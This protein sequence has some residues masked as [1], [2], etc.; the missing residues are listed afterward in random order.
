MGRAPMA[1]GVRLWHAAFAYGTGV[2]A[3]ST[4]RSHKADPM[5]ARPIV[6]LNTSD[7]ASS[8]ER[9]ADCHS[10]LGFMFALENFIFH[11]R[12]EAPS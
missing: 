5:R 1:C 12:P 11:S 9:P 10:H 8:P 6:G 7:R 2:F 3:Y 4:A